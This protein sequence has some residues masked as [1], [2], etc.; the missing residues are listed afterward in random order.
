MS[1]TL[2]EDFHRHYYDSKVW[3]NTFWFGHRI[4]KC[5]LDLMN[6]QEI[7]F[8]IKPDVI[9]ECGT[10]E[11][12]SALFLANI[13]DLLNKGKIITIDIEK[14]E[15]RPIHQ[16]ITY[17]LGD[18]TSPEI[19]KKVKELIHPNDVILV[20]LDSEHTEPHVYKEMELYNQ[21]VSKGSYLIV[22]D[23]NIGGNPIYPNLAPG[24]MGAVQKFLENNENFSIDT[25][26]HKFHLT[27]NPNGYLLKFK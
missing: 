5:P 25:T 13:C 27:F 1:S 10:N 18:S 4:L 21:F 16:K 7:L 17:L 11:G 22:E 24:P 3:I 14:R 12:G 6:Y 19:L 23:T 20:I 15:N 2:I 9:I 8:K 26:K